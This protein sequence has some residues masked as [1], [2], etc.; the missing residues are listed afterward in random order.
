MVKTWNSVAIKFRN[1]WASYGKTLFRIGVLLTVAVGIYRLSVAFPFLLFESGGSSANDLKFR[2]IEVSRWFSGMPI[3]GVFW[4]AVYPPATY[5]ILWPLIG[6]LHY[7]GWHD[8]ASQR[9]VWAVTTV[10]MLSLLAYLCVR[11]SK[12]TTHLEKIFIGSMAFS[13]YPTGLTIYMGQ[14]INHFLPLLLAGLVLLKKSKGRLQYDI[15]AGSLLVLALAKPSTAVPFYWIVLFVPGSVRPFIIVLVGYVLVSLFSA[16]FQESCL[17]T[18]LMEWIKSVPNVHMSQGHANIHKWLVALNLK[19][20]ALPSSL[21]ILLILGGWVFLYRKSNFWILVGVSA[22]VA[23]FWTYHGPYDDLL[24]LLPMISLFRIAKQE[25]TSSG[26]DVIA[27]SLLISSWAVL[28]FVPARIIVYQTLQSM[29]VEII[30]T[31]IWFAIL[32]FLMFYA[33]QE[34]IKKA[35]SGRLLMES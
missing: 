2:S 28:L 21:L 10:P 29:I 25:P 7:N 17:L 11:G 1:F 23:H 8:I 18:L 16:S 24:I 30:Q 4:Y 5:V 26:M 12:A 22:I 27:A 33:W 19:Q 31:V 34:K 15:L 14:L 3:Y 9:I 6:W 32:I 20:L 35:D 13:L